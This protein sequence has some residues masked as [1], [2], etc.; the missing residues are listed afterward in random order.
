MA[1]IAI[2]AACAQPAERWPAMSRSERVEVLHGVADA[3][4]LPRAA[5]A[6]AAGNELMF[7]PPASAS[8]ESVD[9]A[10]AKLKEMGAL[11]RM[12]FVGNAPPSENEQ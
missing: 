3:C 9:C 5:L 11:N 7:R 12:G 4:G 1:A 2:L 10:L 6:P 8:Y